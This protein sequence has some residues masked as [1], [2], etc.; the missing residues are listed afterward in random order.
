MVRAKFYVNSITQSKMYG[1]ETGLGYTVDLNP[2]IGGSSENEKFFRLTPSGSIKLGTI[3][4]EA[5]K[6]FEIGKEYY[7]DFTPAE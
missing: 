7:I 4:E 6:S 2:V 1:S 3:N 5:A